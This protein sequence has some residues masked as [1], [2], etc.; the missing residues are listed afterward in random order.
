MTETLFASP[1]TFRVWLY[2]VGHSTI[3]LRSMKEP[4][5]SSRIDV[6]FK[7]VRYMALPTALTGL[8]VR[9]ANAAEL[10]AL[11]DVSAYCGPTPTIPNPSL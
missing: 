2:S 4:G 1:R 6:V 11:P 10:A 8:E 7:P 3:L 9:L 5:A